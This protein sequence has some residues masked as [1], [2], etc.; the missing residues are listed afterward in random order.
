[1]VPCEVCNKYKGKVNCRKC[2]TIC[3]LHC[4]THY[5]ED[6]DSLYCTKCT[7]RLDET[8]KKRESEG[9]KAKQATKDMVFDFLSSLLCWRSNTAYALNDDGRIKEE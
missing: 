5:Y 3:C 2:S 9:I 1:M 7:D 6:T 4:V 8:E